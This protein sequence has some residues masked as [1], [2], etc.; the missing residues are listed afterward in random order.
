MGSGFP[1]KEGWDG[2]INGKKRAGKWDLRSLLGTLLEGVTISYSL[3][4][5]TLE[6]SSLDLSSVQG[7]C[8]LRQAPR[9]ISTISTLPG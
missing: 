5:W 4:D 3:P 2:G 6:L 7:L 1:S 8:V 9:S